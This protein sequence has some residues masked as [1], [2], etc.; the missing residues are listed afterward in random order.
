MVGAGDGVKS[1]FCL[2]S[3]CGILFARSLDLFRRLSAGVYILMMNVIEWEAQRFELGGI[4]GVRW[5]SETDR[6]WD[7][8][9]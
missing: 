2:V 5:S 6:A 3:C 9:V 8:A 7:R 1:C 4:E